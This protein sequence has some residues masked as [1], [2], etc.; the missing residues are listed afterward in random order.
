MA[1]FPILYEIFLALSLSLTLFLSL[2]LSL[3]SYG[4]YWGYLDT[5]SYACHS[6]L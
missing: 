6:A 3:Q 2:P 4:N 1:P 5:G